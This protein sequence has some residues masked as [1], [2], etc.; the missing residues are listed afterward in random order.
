MTIFVYSELSWHDFI[1]FPCVS[2]EKVV[3]LMSR[4]YQF[5]EHKMVVYGS[6]CVGPFIIVSYIYTDFDS[7]F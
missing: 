1:L 6:V 4:K 3:G 2:K 7:L 5:I